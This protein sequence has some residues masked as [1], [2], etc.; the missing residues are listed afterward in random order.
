MSNLIRLLAVLGILG[1]LLAPLVAYATYTPPDTA[2][3]EAVRVFRHML[4]P[5]DVL[6]LVR[7]DISWG[8]L[9]DQPNAD[10]QQTFAFT[11]VDEDGN[12]TLGNETASTLFNYGY[13]KGLVAFYWADDDAD[14]PVYGDLGNVTLANITD[15]GGNV[16]DTYTLTGADYSAY[17]LPSEIREDLRQWVISQLM[18]INWDWNQWYSENGNTLAVNLLAVFDTYTVLDTAGEAYMQDVQ[19]DFRDMC[20]ALFLFNTAVYDYENQEWDLA[21]QSIYEQEHAAD[22]IGNITAGVKALTGNMVDTIWI[23][24]FV[25]CFAAGALILACNYWWLQ[26]KIGALGA[27][28]IVL[29]ATPQGFFQMGLTALIAV[30]AVLY[31]IDIFFWKRSS[32]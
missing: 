5:N 1:A 23:T 8:N 24:T 13:A 29:V 15:F 3:I 12:A 26:A 21:Q 9:T 2:Q 6:I 25:T 28:C 17:T 11:Y 19:A 10:I 30:L 31:I 14:K 20:P 32:G 4:E 7:Y 18:L 22:W 27:Y 16:T